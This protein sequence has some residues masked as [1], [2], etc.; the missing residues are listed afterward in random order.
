MSKWKIKLPDDFTRWL[1]AIDAESAKV[2]T[3]ALGVMKAETLG[4]W[5]TNIKGVKITKVA[6]EHPELFRLV[7]IST[8]NNIG[9]LY[10]LTVD[11]IIVA[12]FGTLQDI[13]RPTTIKHAQN[14]IT[15]LK[16]VKS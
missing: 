14:V 1:M 11:I 3:K 6:N 10:G 2:L 4:P 9:V 13:S 7:I 16:G 12:A 15:E 5:E 8:E